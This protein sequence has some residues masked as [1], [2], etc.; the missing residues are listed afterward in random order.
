MSL[1][2]SHKRTAVKLA[3]NRRNGR[4]STGPRTPEGK[5]QSS[6][7]SFRHGFYATPDDTVREQMLHIGEDP[8]LLARLERDFT[9]AWQPQDAMQASIVADI[10]RLYMKKSLLERVVRTARLQEKTH[11]ETAIHNLALAPERDEVPIDEDELNKLGYRRI[12]PS[13]TAF[14]EC[15]R[16]LGEF[17]ARVEREDWSGDLDELFSPLY[18]AHPTGIGNSIIDIFNALAKT[19]GGAG[20]QM[21]SAARDTLK[22]LLDCEVNAVM[23]EK[24]SFLNEKREEFM[25]DLGSEWLPGTPNWGFMLSQEAMIDRQI[26]TKSRLLLRLQSARRAAERHA[27]RMSNDVLENEKQ[28]VIQVEEQE[29][30]EDES[31]T[32]ESQ[33]DGSSRPNDHPAAIDQC[34]LE[35]AWKPA[36]FVQK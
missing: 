14:S 4:K 29:W 28:D 2:K 23:E 32:R 9:A 27:A 25:A 35:P 21:N 5:A 19:T 7:N 22:L 13:R 15:L 12:K 24:E 10:A 1:T 34:G 33:V 20:P 11:D 3:A 6:Q 36:N 16:L 18:G 30:R 31:E 26:E 8:D 17:R